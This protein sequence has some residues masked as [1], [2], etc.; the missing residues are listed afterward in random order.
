MRRRVLKV[1][2]AGDV[3]TKHADG[4]GEGADLDVHPTVQAEVVDGATAVAPQDA[5]GVGV[6]HHKYGIVSFGNVYNLRKRGRIAIHTK[7]TVSNH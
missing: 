6:V 5:R 1:L 7:H 4:L 3:S 2:A